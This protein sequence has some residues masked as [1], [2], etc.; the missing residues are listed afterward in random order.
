VYEAYY[1]LRKRP[2]GIGNCWLAPQVAKSVQHA[3]SSLQNGSEVVLVS[4]PVGSGKSAICR[5]L[6]RQLSPKLKSVVLAHCEFGSAGELWRT[7]Q[8]E[9]GLDPVPTT[10]EED[11]RLSVLR[12]ARGLRPRLDGMLIVAD[13]ADA[14]SN[15][16]LDELRRLTVQRHEG[17]PVV[18]LI[19]SGTFALEERLANPDLTNLSQRIGQHIVL[20]SLSRAESRAYIAFRV[21]DAGGE[22]NEV[23]SDAALDAIVAASDGNLHCLN[24]LCDHVLLL[25]F[26]NEERPVSA[27]IVTAALEDLKGLS[28]PWNLPATPAAAEV[29]QSAKILENIRPTDSP[30]PD[31][32][33]ENASSALAVRAADRRSWWDDV[34]DAAIIEVGAPTSQSPPEPGVMPPSNPAFAARPAGDTPAVEIQ[35]IAVDDGYATLDRLSELQSIDRDAVRPFAAERPRLPP[36][37]AATV[38]ERIVSPALSSEAEVPTYKQRGVETR[39][40]IDVTNLRKEIRAA[41]ATVP[42]TPRVPA[43]RV[44]EMAPTE[45]D[46]DVVQP[47]PDAPAAIWPDR[48]GEAPAIRRVGATKPLIEVASLRAELSDKAAP[49]AETPPQR[50]SARLF[51]RLQ[52]RRAETAAE[53]ASPPVRLWR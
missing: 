53:S 43:A 9:A 34:G 28:L 2:F 6:A 29:P 30:Q 20:D 31:I 8:F 5:E 1:L 10:C 17:R 19:L 4:G 48:S 32:T 35:E 39:L 18:Q 52:Q 46:W 14:L 24:Q 40:L 33:A 45:P 36:A 27:D 25:G 3:V 37:P 42:E 26:A 22:L 13:D 41:A 7:I 15:S 23:F 51:T 49:P 38:A 12:A 21:Q 50:R 11:A 44:A 47:E 16:L